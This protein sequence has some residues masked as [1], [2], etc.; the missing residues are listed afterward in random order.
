MTSS[1][2]ASRRGFLQRVSS[3]TAG[4]A[5]LAGLAA[6]SSAAAAQTKPAVSGTPKRAAKAK[7]MGDFRAA[8][9]AQV[10]VAII[11][12]GARGSGHA[13]QLAAIEGVQFV[14]IADVVEAR[15]KKSEAEVRKFG[16][17]PKVYSGDENGWRKML[18]ETKPD[19]VFINTP[20]SSHAPMAIAAMQAGAHAFVEVPIATTLKE[21]WDIVDTS[22]ATGRH[23]MMMENVNYG[24]E[25]LL[26][27]N[28]VRQGVLGD[29]LHGEA[30]YIHALRF[31]ME[32]GDSTGSWRTFEYAKRN[33]NLYPTHGLGPVAQYM[34]LARGEDTFGRISSF[35]SPAKGRAAYA[36]K[37]NKLTSPAFKELDFKGGDLN[38]SIIKTSLGRTIMV[39]WDETTPRPYSRHNMIMGVNGVLTGFPNRISVEGITSNYHKWAEGKEWEEIAAKYEH[40]LYVRLGELSKKMGGHGGMD[41]LMLYRIIECLRKGEA[42][43]QNVY[44][45]CFWS[46]V[47]PLSEKS[48]AEDGNSQVF[49]DFT[50]GDWK[51]TN[52]LKII[53]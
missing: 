42:L 23:C 6:H 34:N 12:V 26:Y 2:T 36:Q 10:K 20:W 47:G 14:G 37:S 48:V 32:N 41:F 21:M 11:G 7:Y 43:D 52:P 40:P 16:H 51:T 31:Q 18:A 29:L 24:R 15:A 35:S 3:L 53:V 39:Q 1:N 38:T 5:S 22:E 17:T 33:G 13:A 9:L 25:E 44:E 19:A 8:S 28:M 30:S 4:V 46:A 50:R 49:P 45:G 27:L